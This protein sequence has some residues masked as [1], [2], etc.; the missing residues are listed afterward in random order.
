MAKADAK[1]ELKAHGA[2]V[3]HRLGQL[4]EAIQLRL[5]KGKS[6][7]VRVHARRIAAAQKTGHQNQIDGVGRP[8][9]QLAA[10]PPRRR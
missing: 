3:L 1:P 9:R 6:E 2:W 4:D 10:S 5:G 7:L 8:A